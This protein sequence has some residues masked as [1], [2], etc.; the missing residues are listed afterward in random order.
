MPGILN[1][2]IFSAIPSL[3]S[4][5]RRD[6]YWSS[7]GIIQ[8]VKTLDGYGIEVAIPSIVYPANASHAV[9]SREAE[10][11][12]NEIHDHKEE[13]KS[14]DEFLTAEKEPGYWCDQ[15]HQGTLCEL[16]RI[17]LVI[18]YSR[19]QLLPYVNENRS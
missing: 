16:P 14:S 19:R 6:N 2:S 11:F 10:R 18:L 4:S 13:L 5:S 17:L 3:G 8:L 12:V 15:L 7:V 9:I 1:F